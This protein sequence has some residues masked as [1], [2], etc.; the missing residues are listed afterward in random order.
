MS[1]CVCPVYMSCVHRST[2]HL[3]KLC[4]VAHESIYI[5]CNVRVYLSRSYEFCSQKYS[6]SVQ[7][8]YSISLSESIYIKGYVCVCVLFI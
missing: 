3:Y 4:T 2:V 1:V 5:K 6:S 7:I 8:V